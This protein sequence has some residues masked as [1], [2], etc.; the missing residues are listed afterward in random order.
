MGSFCFFFLV[1]WFCWVFL[2]VLE[3]CLFSFSF[4]KCRPFKL[5]CSHHIRKAYHLN[6]GVVGTGIV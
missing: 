5:S 4:Y 2:F 1:G 6:G 3:F